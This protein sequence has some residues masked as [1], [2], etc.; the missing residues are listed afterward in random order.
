M[1]GLR[2]AIII[3]I[4][5]IF[6]SRA[7]EPLRWMIQRRRLSNHSLHNVVTQ[8]KVSVVT[9]FFGSTVTLKIHRNNQE[10]VK[11]KFLKNSLPQ[12]SIIKRGSTL[13]LPL[14]KN[15]MVCSNRAWVSDFRSL[16]LTSC[17]S[18]ENHAASAPY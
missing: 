4:L 9:G 10:E 13:L 18:L 3:I 17:G 5:I 14:S 6:F 11:Q 2:F 7:L 15:A 16:G 12:L 8:Q 1:G